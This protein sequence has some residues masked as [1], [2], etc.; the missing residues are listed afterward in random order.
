MAA[1]IMALIVMGFHIYISLEVV[2]PLSPMHRFELTIKN[3]QPV[4]GYVDNGMCEHSLSTEL[5]L[6]FFNTY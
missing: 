3:D 5:N 4:Q 1:F 2:C 6:A